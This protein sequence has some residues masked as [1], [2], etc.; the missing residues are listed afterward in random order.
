MVEI[1][2]TNVAGK[3]D[4]EEENIKFIG[5][6]HSDLGKALLE[7]ITSIGYPINRIEVRRKGGG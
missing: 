1:T 2:F 7:Y 6:E 4:G 5:E 3:Y